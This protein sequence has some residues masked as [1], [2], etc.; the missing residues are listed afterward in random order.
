MRSKQAAT[1][2][3]RPSYVTQGGTWRQFAALVHL[4]HF[5]SV[6]VA[7]TIFGGFFGEGGLN[8]GITFMA[9]LSADVPGF[10]GSFDHPRGTSEPSC[11]VLTTGVQAERV[12]HLHNYGIGYICEPNPMLG[13]WADV[14]AM[15]VNVLARYDSRT[16]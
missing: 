8:I 7:F 10:V 14:G 1:R 13:R 3:T 12:G 15:Q 4:P 16:T 11:P 5:I 2:L 9:L 6:R